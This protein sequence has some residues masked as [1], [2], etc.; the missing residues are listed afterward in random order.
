MFFLFPIEIFGSKHEKTRWR[1]S[2]AG[3]YFFEISLAV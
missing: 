3:W 2:P 1:L